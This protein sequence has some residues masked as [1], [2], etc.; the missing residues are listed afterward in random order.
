MTFSKCWLLLLPL[1]AQC[2]DSG[3]EN[4]SAAQEPTRGRAD[5]PQFD[6][7]LVISIDGLRSDAIQ[8]LG[9]DKLPNLTR[10]RGGAWTLNARTDPT[11]TVTLPNHTGMITG[12]SVEGPQGH[13]WT[14]NDLPK[15]DRDLESVFGG[16]LQTAFHV[17]SENQ[18][19][20]AVF[21]TKDKFKIWS[22]TWG[23]GPDSPIQTQVI[24]HQETKSVVD[25][26][27]AHLQQRKAERDLVFVHLHDCDTTGHAKG[28]N[29]TKDSAYLAT[30]QDVDATLGRI[31]TTIDSTPEL[32]A[33]TAILITADHGG[34][35]PYKNHHGQGLQWI[36]YVIPFFAWSSNGSIP[37][38]EFYQLNAGVR[39]DPSLGMPKIEAWPPPVR[40]LDAGN[41]ALALL[42]LPAIVG[43]EV[44]AGQELA[45]R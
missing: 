5:L 31:L 35:V 13:R 27:I 34:G 33:S 32:A 40:N 17:A 10:L 37:T 22:T 6:D 7:V 41:L 19:G 36:N 11:F 1:L 42:G 23:V 24:E 25:Q 28:W 15:D 26:L 2:G 21:A 38:G 14:L 20:T 44:N 43:S 12:R 8:A 39:L 18:V 4:E 29:L 3:A 16:E 9:D 30:L 45:L